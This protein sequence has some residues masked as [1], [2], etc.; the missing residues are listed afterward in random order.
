FG[1]VCFT[2]LVSAL[3]EG[4][5]GR[6][7]EARSLK[8]VWA[9][10]FCRNPISTKN[11]KIRLGTVAHACNTSTLG[12]RG[13]RIT[14]SGDQNHPGQRGQNPVSTKIQNISRVWWCARVVPAT[15]EAEA[16]ESLEPGRWRLQ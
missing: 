13:G 9:T 14:R 12:G 7:F 5:V 8:P 3:W 6:S 16:G 11:T 2:P 1:Q 4:E 15:W 10:Q